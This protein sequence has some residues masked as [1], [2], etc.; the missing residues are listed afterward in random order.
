M[1]RLLSSSYTEVCYG[2]RHFHKKTVVHSRSSVGAAGVE[3]GAERLKLGV[4]KKGA[5]SSHID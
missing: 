1:I 3:P 5:K 2:Y 4:K